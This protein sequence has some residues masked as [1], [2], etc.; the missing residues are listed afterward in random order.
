MVPACRKRKSR[1][2]LRWL[3][4]SKKSKREEWGNRLP[5]GYEKKNYN[6]NNNQKENA[7]CTKQSSVTRARFFIRS[8]LFRGIFFFFFKFRIKCKITIRIRVHCVCVCVCWYLIVYYNSHF[9]EL[10]LFATPLDV[11]YY[12]QHQTADGDVDARKVKRRFV[13]VQ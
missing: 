4:L 12:E 11:R 1:L 7:L 5:A 9:L 3:T 10:L 6:N 13:R 8:I 2:K